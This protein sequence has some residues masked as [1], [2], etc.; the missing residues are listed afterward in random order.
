MADAL[1][2]SR[3][4]GWEVWLLDG[5]DRRLRLLDEVEGGDLEIAALSRLGASGTL[6]L[7]NTRGDVNW[8][9]HRVQ[10]I[11]DPGITGV[12]AWPVATMLLSSP[13]YSYDEEGLGYSVTLLSK[14]AVLDEDGLEATLSLP[15]GTPI[16][17]TVVALIQSSG[18]ARIAATLSD[19]AL[20]SPKVYE[21]GESK[22]TVINDLLDT[23]GY[24]SLW[25]DG[26][27][28]FRVEPYVDISSRPVARRFDS[29]EYTS[30]LLP[31]WEQEQDLSSVPNKVIVI[32]QGDDENPPL[33]GI[34]TNEDPT[35]PFSYQARGRWIT[36]VERDVDGADQAVFDQLAQRLLVSGMSP[37]SRMTVRHAIVPLDPNALVRFEPVGASPRLATVMSMKYTL[38]EDS[39]CEAEW[40]GV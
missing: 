37:V 39:D 26:A 15:E 1:T 7:E 13:T 23:A 4:S 36:R 31:E 30:I 21:S 12:S 5:L 2:G 18:E 17:P 20:R 32:G 27:G 33:I 16:I 24:W 6:S 11:Y 35:S 14:L 22:L 34:A 19:A 3:V 9:R 8:L 25:C 28:Q 10:C 40:R 38:A 29:G